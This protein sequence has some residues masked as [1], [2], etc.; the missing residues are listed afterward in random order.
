MFSPGVRKLVRKLLVLAVLVACLVVATPGRKAA[1]FSCCS[2][3]KQSYDAC[4]PE[5]RQC[6]F[7]CEDSYYSCIPA[8]Y[9][10][11]CPWL[12]FD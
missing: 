8:C 10:L 3:C 2:A 11:E 5:G 7:D 6:P 9:P 12:P 1:A 4:C